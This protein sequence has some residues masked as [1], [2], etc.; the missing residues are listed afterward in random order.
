[1]SNILSMIKELCTKDGITIA[2]LERNLN[3]S[4]ALISKWN[5]SIPTIDKVRLVADYFNVSVDYLLGR[6]DISSTI[7]ETLSDP[8]LVT[9]QRLRSNLS[10][11]DK[12]KMMQMMRIQFA[13]DFPK[14][15]GDDPL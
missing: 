7:D 9:I 3:F 13:E 10:V 2:E 15:D 14:E 5:K 11:R 4:S 1:M 12:E 8:D 6:T